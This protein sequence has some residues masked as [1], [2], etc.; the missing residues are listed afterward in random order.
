[1]SDESANRRLKIEAH[2]ASRVEW[3]MYIPLPRDREISE[4]E[5]SFRLEFPE[6]IYVPHDG[7]EQLQ[8]LARLSSPDE[9]SFAPEP[10]TVDGLRRSALGVARRLKLLRESIPR[11]AVAHSLN[12]MP[13]APSLAKELGR[14]LDQAVATL[15]QARAMLVGPRAD[16]APELA[17]ERALADEFLSGQLLELLTVAEET[18]ARMLAPAGLPG[19]RAVAQKLRGRVADALAE[20]LRHRERKG[21]M[22]PDGEDVEALAL[23]LDRAA[24]LKKHFQEV[25]FLE[26]ETKMIDEAVRNWVG[27]SGAAT[28]FIIYFGLQALQ[29]SAAAG[30]G[31]WTLMTVGAVAYAL[32][33]RAKELTRQWLAGKL[34]HL[35]ANRVLALRE[36]QKFERTRNVVLRARES[37]AQS[38]LAMP[39]PL[40]PGSG[41]VQR[42]VTLD[43]RQRARV[44]RLKGPSAPAFERLK[45]VFRYDL[46]P[47]LTRLDDSVKRVPVPAGAGVRFADAPRLYQVP[48]TLQVATS[49]GVERREALIVLNR[50]GIARI[51][52][53]GTA[54]P[55]PPAELELPELDDNGAELLPQT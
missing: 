51:V 35:Y 39:D 40:N 28:A 41:A 53:E 10:L 15:G 37:I 24:Q 46:A 8:I 9:E 12:P 16:D 43:Y 30:L 17:R 1:M 36:P 26:P 44:T 18:C 14:I 25:L 21:E 48:L 13:V 50:R 29:T 34:S 54:Q 20:E 22:L 55:A 45:I 11:V 19:Y 27:L 47:I 38:R 42:V 31:L 32:K 5:V 49:A 6:N 33:D 52:P 7:W 23:F 3:S 4:A 2:D